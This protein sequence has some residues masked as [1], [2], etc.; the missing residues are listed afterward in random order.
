MQELSSVDLNTVSCG[1]GN[2]NVCTVKSNCTN[3]PAPDGY[4][5]VFKWPSEEYKTQFFL[6]P[7]NNDIYMRS[8]SSEGVW[9]DW[10]KK[11]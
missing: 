5:F 1:N 7:N 10:I 9:G 8:T 4:M 3:R 6:D 2:Y 11:A